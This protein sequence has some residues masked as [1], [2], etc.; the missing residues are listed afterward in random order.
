MNKKVITIIIGGILM[1]EAN[2][3]TANATV[4]RPFAGS[5]RFDTAVK[6]S[7]YGWKTKSISA[8][9]S[10]GNNSNLVDALTAA[11][12]AKK[13][14]APIFFTD[15]QT[16]DSGTLSKLKG[17]GVTTVYL[18][19]GV[20]VI[21]TNVETILKNAGIKDIIRL[22]GAN[23]YE[24]AVNIA[25]VVG[26]SGRVM[27]ARSDECA[28]ALSA[29]AIA[30]KEGIPIL[31]SE[32]DNLSA[33]TKKFINE[34]N[35]KTTYILG[36]QGAISSNVESE[37]VGA[38]RL[39]GNT[40][41]DTNIEIIKEFQDGLDFNKT[42]IASGESANLVDAL[43][44][45]PLAASE[46]APVV[47]VSSTLPGGAETYL[48]VMLSKN[49]DVKILGG[50]GAVPIAVS[51][52]L[53]SIQ[54]SLSTNIV[55]AQASVVSGE[56]SVIKE[57]TITNISLGNVATFRIEGSSL[58]PSFNQ[59]ITLLIKGNQVD[60]YF[61]SSSNQLIGKGTLDVTSDGNIKS[62]DVSVIK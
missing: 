56:I 10:A 57:V 55:K 4:N 12:L 52:K 17:L 46:N 35:I 44:G 22:G 28:D 16:I 50:L 53:S 29:A 39:G 36:L 7:N 61:Y 21:S 59:K 41:Y 45:A 3:Y 25:N 8:V 62:F 51:E 19:S 5:N 33:E 9:L 30:A 11:P 54:N 40:R 38:K 13:L 18:T 31:L 58:Q 15:G 2:G 37:L 1:L 32:R 24:T 43:A 20:G 47:L 48:S 60:V 23:R 42:Y 26:T 6:I 27:I 49:S 34:N 14:K